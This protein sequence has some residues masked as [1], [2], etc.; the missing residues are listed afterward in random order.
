MET[1]IEI[2]LS[3]IESVEYIDCNYVYDI[4][5]KDNHNFILE[6]GVLV[7]NSSK[8]YTILLKLLLATFRH[9][10]VAIYY[11]RKN[12]E[13]IRT[14][15]FKDIQYVMKIAGIEH[16]FE[17]STAFNSSMIVKNKLTGNCMY[18][19][20]LSEAEKTKGISEATHIFVD[21]ITENTKESIDMIDSVLRTPQAEYLQFIGA[22]N[23]VDENNFVRKYFFDENDAFKGRADYGDDLLIHHSTLEHNEYIDKE[24]YKT[25]LIRKYGHNQNLL[26]VNLYGL[27]G[28]AEVD[29][30]FANRFDKVK[31]VQSLS[32]NKKSYRLSFDFNL[33]PMTCL[34]ATDNPNKLEIV[35]EFRLMGAGG[36]GSDIY[37][38]CKEIRE[39]LPKGSYIEVT[40]D[41][42]G[43]NGSAMTR[44]NVNYY[45]IIV[46]E[47]LL[48]Y[49]QIKTPTYNIGHINSRGLV[50]TLLIENKVSIDIDCKWLIQDLVYSQVLP[51]GSIAKKLNEASNLGHLLD[52]FR[53]LCDTYFNV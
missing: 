39:W 25:S 53:Y 8:T 34:V 3:K 37:E 35:K 32:Y 11:C 13:T 42:T 51:D 18:P 46:K 19:Y 50:N 44:G 21:E 31:H 20:G 22:F 16:N 2:D 7:H 43:K 28:R 40:G 29:A 6:S 17:F 12:F 48:S 15:T 52:C 33:K 1:H 10:H 47:L 23:P 36:G 14:N 9:N 5:V 30:P 26:D 27:W 49:S 45:D 38:M 41:A 24:A 4:E